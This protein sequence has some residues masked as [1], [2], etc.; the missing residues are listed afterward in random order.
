VEIDLLRAGQRAPVEGA[1]PCDYCVLV[2][3][4]SDFPRA[5]FW[6][7]SIRDELPTVPIPLDPGVDEVSVS[8]RDCFGEA[9]EQGR[10]SDDINY[11]E[12][13]PPPEL[14]AADMQWVR[15]RLAAFKVG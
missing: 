7:L 13:P 9:F 1:E 15:E 4:T 6:P 8:L 12:S 10:Y 2:S 3:R 14:S 11:T 5:G